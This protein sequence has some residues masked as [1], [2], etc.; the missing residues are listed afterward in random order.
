MGP[1]EKVKY[2]VPN[3]NMLKSCH[4]TLSINKFI[5]DRTYDVITEM[6]LLIY[7]MKVSF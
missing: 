1:L 6:R 5:K 2:R 4:T 3:Q 7:K